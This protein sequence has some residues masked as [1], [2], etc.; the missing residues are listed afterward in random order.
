MAASDWVTSLAVLPFVV[1]FCP[2]IHAVSYLKL[3]H[4]SKFDIATHRQPWEFQRRR[5]ATVAVE[6]VGLQPVG[7]CPGLV[8]REG[9]RRMVMEGNALT[10]VSAY[11]TSLP[12]V[13]HQ[14]FQKASH[15]VEFP[16]QYCVEKN[17]HRPLR[18]NDMP[19]RTFIILFRHRIN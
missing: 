7:S 10:L 9:Y 8:G 11:C 16:A 17:S 13:T 2:S 3:G 18:D 12:C 5:N 1:A 14:G 19:G 6:Q 15:W 4:G